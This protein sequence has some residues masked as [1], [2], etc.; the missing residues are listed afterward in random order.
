MKRKEI[1][2]HREMW[3][4]EEICKEISKLRGNWKKKKVMLEEGKR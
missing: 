1:R 3:E 4:M 2:R